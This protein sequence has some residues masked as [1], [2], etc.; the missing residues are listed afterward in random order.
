MICRTMGLTLTSEE[1]EAEGLGSAHQVPRPQVPPLQWISTMVFNSGSYKPRDVR[2]YTWI[3][4]VP[5]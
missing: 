3:G 5:E 4:E 2:P 1:R